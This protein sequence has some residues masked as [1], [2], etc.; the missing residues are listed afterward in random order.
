MK[1]LLQR[2]TET[3]LSTQGHLAVNGVHECFTLEPPGPQFKADHHRISAGVYKIELYTSP[4]FGR[5][6]PLLKYTPG[7][8][9]CEIHFGNVPGASHCCIL[10][11]VE[12]GIN[13]IFHTRDAFDALFPVI[14]VAVNHE[15]CEIEI[16]DALINAPMGVDEVTQI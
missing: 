10:V 9:K 4:H 3:P 8:D 5:M 11:G 7:C 15:G 1:I 2:V 14:E 12:K 6:M 16:V 13:I